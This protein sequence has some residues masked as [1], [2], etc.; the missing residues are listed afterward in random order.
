[1]R[2]TAASRG[3]AAGRRNLAWMRAKWPADRLDLNVPNDW[4]AAPALLKSFEAASFARVQVHAPP[5]S[6]LSDSRQCMPHATALAAALATTGLMPV[7]HAAQDLRVGAREADRAAEGLLGLRGRD[8][9]HSRRLPRLRSAGRPGER[10]RAAVRGS[11]AGC[12][13]AARRAAWSHD[14]GREPGAGLPRAGAAVG[15]PDVL[16]GR[17]NRIGSE[18]IGSC[19][20]VGHAHIVA[21]L[22]RTTLEAL[23]EPVLD[24]VTLFHAHDNLGA[25]WQ[26]VGA[27][28]GVDPLRLD[29]HLPPGRGTLPWERVAPRLAA[30]RL[31]S[32][33]RCIRRI[34]RARRSCIAP[35]RS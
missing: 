11:L 26:P 16:R 10:G 13:V 9:R 28:S 14:R 18:R 27:E 15:E 21:E 25:R 33:S 17:V 22:R 12:S 32:C 19:L 2:F 30:T 5:P 35:P 20:D 7:V 6:V 29:L 3:P 34:A 8:R 23:I 31:P 1:M 24:T 4:W